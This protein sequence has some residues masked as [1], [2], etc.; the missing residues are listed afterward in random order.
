MPA[1]DADIKEAIG[2]FLGN[3]AKAGM[4]GD[5]IEFLLLCESLTAS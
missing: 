1:H 5:K 4:K 3:W 2:L